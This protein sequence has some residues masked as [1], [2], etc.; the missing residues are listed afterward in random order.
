[1]PMELI[2]GLHNLRD[3]SRGAIE[4]DRRTA[5]MRTHSGLHLLSGVVF[6]DFGALVTGSNMDPLT[7]RL[8]FNLE[9]VPPGFKESVEAACNVEVDADRAISALA[10]R[11]AVPCVLE[12]DELRRAPA[13]VEAAAYFVVAEALTNVAKH[14]GA[15]RVT[16]TAR[17]ET[18][19][20]PSGETML[21]DVIDDGHGGANEGVIHM[22]QEI[23]S[24][25][26]VAKW[27]EEALAQKKKI[28]CIGHRDYKVLDP[29]APHLRAMAIKL[30]EQLGAEGGDV[31]EAY[32][33][34]HEVGHHVQNLLGTSDK[35]NAMRG[36]PDYNQYSV[37]LE[38]QADCY[39][40][41]WGHH[42][43]TMNQ[44]DSGDIAEALNAATAI[45]DDRLQRQSRGTV[46]PDSFTH[47]TSEQRVR[48]FRRGIES[49]DLKQC[50]T[51][52]VRQL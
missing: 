48:W 5:L 19:D 1:M 40:G 37:R 31:A 16:V 27:I 41:V 28:M 11:S 17:T 39:A 29:R 33:I 2:R 45:G 14:S 22:L 18:S 52:S 35:V 15:R 49:G 36:R 6:R 26:N 12:I 10:G 24:L 44:L 8:D 34:A 25:E 30:T 51:F 20:D 4:D 50:D 32:V 13:A 23:G 46:V 42:A 43:G 7:G 3:A 9:E 21:I 38:L 47:G